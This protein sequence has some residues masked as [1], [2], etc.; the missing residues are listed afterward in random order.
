MVKIFSRIGFLAAI[1]TLSSCAMSSRDY[2]NELSGYAITEGRITSIENLNT[3]DVQPLKDGIAVT[4]GIPGCRVMIQFENGEQKAFD[5]H[6]G[7][8]LVHGYECDFIVR[9]ELNN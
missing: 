8:I 9:S 4:V 5:V 1:A 2:V 7:V 6:S 3:Q